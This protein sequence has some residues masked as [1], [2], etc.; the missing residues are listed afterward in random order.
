MI[1]RKLEISWQKTTQFLFSGYH[2]IFLKHSPLGS[3]EE[4]YSALKCAIKI[5]L[6]SDL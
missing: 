4:N 6:F 5:S 3:T 1:A 2:S